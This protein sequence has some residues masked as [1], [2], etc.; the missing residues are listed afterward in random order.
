MNAIVTMRILQLEEKIKEL[1]KR[2]NT[3]ELGLGYEVNDD[4]DATESDIY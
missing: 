3:L 4:C 2:L 1:E